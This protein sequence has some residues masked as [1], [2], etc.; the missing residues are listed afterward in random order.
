MNKFSYTNQSK[1][2]SK[3]IHSNKF[4][5]SYLKD[6]RCSHDQGGPDQ[7][8]SLV[9]I[10]I[11]TESH[12]TRH[13]WRHIHQQW[14]IM[15]QYPSLQKIH[16][17]LDESASRDIH[18]GII[19]SR[20]LLSSQCMCTISQLHEQLQSYL[21]LKAKWELWSSICSVIITMHHMRI[22]LIAVHIYMHQ[23]ANN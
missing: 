16:F 7:S 11:W 13:W 22:H 2:K 12:Y 21:L 1:W 8:N 17:K 10:D 18:D 20:Y 3:Q 19:N 23:M 9:D 6:S 5:I 4:K 15:H 14:N